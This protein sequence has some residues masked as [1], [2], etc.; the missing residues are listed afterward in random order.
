[1]HARTHVR[2]HRHPPRM[3]IGTTGFPSSTLQK[4]LLQTPGRGL[5]FPLT[6]KITRAAKNRRG[7]NPRRVVVPCIQTTEFQGKRTLS[8]PS[9]VPPPPP[10]PP[11][12]DCTREHHV[13]VRYLPSGWGAGGLGGGNRCRRLRCTDSRYK[14]AGGR[15]SMGW[16]GRVGNGAGGG[17]GGEWGGGA[18]IG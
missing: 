3:E 12:S 1:M 15:V 10:P 6:I 9:P 4:Q 5:R 13:S 11:T 14:E 2:T 7:R 16:K 8:I 17:G 18:G